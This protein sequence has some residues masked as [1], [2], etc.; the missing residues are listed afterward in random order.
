[1]VPVIINHQHIVAV[2]E[3]GSWYKVTIFSN[4]FAK[5]GG[6]GVDD[7]FITSNGRCKIKIDKLKRQIE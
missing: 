7:I 4:S 1:M 5:G 3:L 6:G 2:E